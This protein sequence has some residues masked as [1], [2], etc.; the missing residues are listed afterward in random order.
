MTTKRSLKRK[1]SSSSPVAALEGALLG[2]MKR[3]AS[4]PTLRLKQWPLALPWGVT[5]GAAGGGSEAA[6]PLVYQKTVGTLQNLFNNAAS[7]SAMRVNLLDF[8][9]QQ[10]GYESNANARDR[11]FFNDCLAHDLLFFRGDQGK[12]LLSGLPVD[13]KLYSALPQ[14]EVSFID[15]HYIEE[16]GWLGG[17][18]ARSLLRD[19]EV[20][21][22]GGVR[23][24]KGPKRGEY[25]LGRLVRIGRGKLL[26]AP[27]LRLTEAQAKAAQAHFQVELAA[28]QTKYPGLSA[29]A[30]LKVAGYHL[31]EYAASMLLR[32][33]LGAM[34]PNPIAL[35]P[36]M[37]EWTIR[38]HQRAAVEA[39]FG[40]LKGAKTLESSEDGAY[41]M[42]SLPLAKD[43][44]IHASL[45]DALLT[46]DLQT[47]NLIAFIDPGQ[48]DLISQI[49]TRLPPSLTPTITDLDPNAVYRSLRHVVRPSALS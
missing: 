31:Y 32:E 25:I 37:I 22:D 30:L 44:M 6:N 40:A 16:R 34:L 45:R 24:F 11:A 36:R 8:C 20:I 28:H 48:D 33:E 7:L 27:L 39:N 17:I 9:F 1:S 41:L 42:L 43:T 3:E 21:E 46:L 35:R 18:K 12:T 26:D 47:L 29:E 38:S 5:G 23:M 13:G 19:G 14:M 2:E 4:W 15:I 10:G 49:Q